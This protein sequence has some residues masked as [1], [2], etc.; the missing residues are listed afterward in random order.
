MNFL[1]LDQKNEFNHLIQNLDNYKNSLEVLNQISCGDKIFYNISN[2]CFSLSTTKKLVDYYYGNGWISTQI[3]KTSRKLY[4][5]NSETTVKAFD[6]FTEKMKDTINAIE[7]ASQQPIFSMKQWKQ[8]KSKIKPIFD[9]MRGNELSDHLSTLVNSYQFNTHLD[10]EK[11]ENSVN[12]AKLFFSECINKLTEIENDYNHRKNEFKKL[13]IDVDGNIKDLETT[14]QILERKKIELKELVEK[15]NKK[16]YELFE[17][18]PNEFK[19]Y[20]LKQRFWGAYTRFDPELMPFN[21]MGFDTLLE[22][23]STIDTSV[24]EI[25]NEKN[26]KGRNKISSRYNKTQKEIKEIKEFIQKIDRFLF[27]YNFEKKKNKLRK[28]LEKFQNL[29]LSLRDLS[30]QKKSEEDNKLIEIEKVNKLNEISQ[31]E[32]ELKEIIF[33]IN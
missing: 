8:I 22:L 30:E 11:I 10:Y 32:K 14:V 13:K 28:K 15:N 5:E 9:M 3:Q 23:P 18:Y 16:V 29:P 1:E 2:S 33:E 12:K 19:S 21:F 31:L 17:K 20:F 4:G 26:D 7:N 27:L 6:D 24:E 25:V